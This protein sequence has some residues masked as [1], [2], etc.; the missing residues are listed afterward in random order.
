MKIILVLILVFF[1]LFL[2]K[3]SIKKYKDYLINK[4]FRS[5]R[6]GDTIKKGKKIGNIVNGSFAEKYLQLIK[7]EQKKKLNYDIIQK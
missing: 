5:Y 1:I 2:I 3:F 6:L 7:N 4:G